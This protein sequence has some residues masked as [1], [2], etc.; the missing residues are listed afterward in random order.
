MST[1]N[2]PNYEPKYKSVGPMVTFGSPE[3]NDQLDAPTTCRGGVD[4]YARVG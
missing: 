1:F 3:H 2:L 4:Q